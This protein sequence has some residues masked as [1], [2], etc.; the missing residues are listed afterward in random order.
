ME[1]TEEK[2]KKRAAEK[3]KQAKQRELDV[4]N[5]NISNSPVQ[6]QSDDLYNQNNSK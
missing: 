1:K 3:Q 4:L 2:Q 6:Q 5:T